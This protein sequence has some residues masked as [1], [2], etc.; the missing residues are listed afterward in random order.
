[1]IGPRDPAAEGLT[2]F[3]VKLTF[4]CGVVHQAIVWTRNWSQAINMALTD[5]RMLSLNPLPEGELIAQSA[6]RAN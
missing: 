4:S 1:M 2:R 6:I 5:A 3:R